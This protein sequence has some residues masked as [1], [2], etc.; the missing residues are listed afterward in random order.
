MFSRVIVAVL[1]AATVVACSDR[2]TPVSPALRPG[3]APATSLT[4]S[5]AQ[6]V[7]QLTASRGIVPLPKAPRV[8]PE[9]V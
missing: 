5:T 6:L 1:A 8:R 4:L 2:I 7:R 9:L 3:V